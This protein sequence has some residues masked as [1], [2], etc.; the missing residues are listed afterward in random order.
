MPAVVL[1]RWPDFRGP[2]IAAPAP[3]AAH[4]A[5]VLTERGRRGAGV[6]ASFMRLKSRT[7]PRPT[8]AG[9]RCGAPPCVPAVRR[10]VSAL[11]TPSLD[12]DDRAS[13]SN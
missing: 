10:E 12:A 1:R 13:L 4:D 7:H 9:R 8:V 5:Y 2:F 6:S 3:L 11:F